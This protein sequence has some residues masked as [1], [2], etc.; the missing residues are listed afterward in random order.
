MPIIAA[1]FHEPIFLE[2]KSYIKVDGLWQISEVAT[3]VKVDT[4]YDKMRI[5]TVTGDTIT[6]DNKDSTITLSKNKVIPLMGDFKMM[7]SDQDIVDDAN[8][9]RYYLFKSREVFPAGGSL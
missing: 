2:D 9:Q 4:E 8:P 6:M 3:E 1:H 7:T 5:A